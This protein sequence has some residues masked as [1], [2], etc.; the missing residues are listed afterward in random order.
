[1]DPVLESAITD[2]QRHW[3]RAEAFKAILVRLVER[4]D[5]ALCAGVVNWDEM[6]E[7]KKLLQEDKP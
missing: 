3:K 2:A 1:M 5:H 4:L 6:A 7:A